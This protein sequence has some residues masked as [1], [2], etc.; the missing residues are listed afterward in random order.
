MANKLVTLHW[1]YG[2][3]LVDNTYVNGKVKEF[4]DMDTDRLSIP[5][6][7]GYV[8]EDFVYI[9]EQPVYYKAENSNSFM[10]C[11]S[12]K[13][14]VDLTLRFSDVEGENVDL[15]GIENEEDNAS[16][17]EDIN[18]EGEALEEDENNEANRN[19]Y[20]DANEEVIAAREELIFYRRRPKI[21]QIQPI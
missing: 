6:L 17:E 16:F 13:F 7:M 5:E 8:K 15:V 10:P 18:T 1:H 2:G 21:S 14:I 4:D 12:D 19:G 20:S 9:I 11:M 3:Y